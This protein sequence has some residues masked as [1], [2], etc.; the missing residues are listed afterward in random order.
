MISAMFIPSG[1][2]GSPAG[3]ADSNPGGVRLGEAASGILSR[4]LLNLLAGSPRAGIHE[5]KPVLAELMFADATA[6]GAICGLRFAPGGRSPV[7][8]RRGDPMACRGQ[9]LQLLAGLDR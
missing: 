7:T 2:G 1:S 8:R 6:R 3:R 4:T 9:T 5:D